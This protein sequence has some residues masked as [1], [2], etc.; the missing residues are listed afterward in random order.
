MKKNILRAGEAGQRGTG[1]SG[2]HR[3]KGYESLPV[4][5]PT[6]RGRPGG[7]AAES[8]GADNGALSGVF[9]GTAER[10]FSGSIWSSAICQ[11]K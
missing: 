9:H 7:S 10:S 2:G 6:E 5:L 8:A 11:Q 3:K 1:D 4:L